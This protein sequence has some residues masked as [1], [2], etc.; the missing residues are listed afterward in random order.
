MEEKKI[1]VEATRDWGSLIDS[2]VRRPRNEGERWSI[3]QLRLEALQK[4]PKARDLIKV[5]EQVETATIEPKEVK[6]AKKKEVKKPVK[7]AV[8]KK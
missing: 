7:K 6:V 8:K 4:H 5:V 2:E 1:L 3:S